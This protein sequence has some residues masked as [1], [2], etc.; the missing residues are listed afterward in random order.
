MDLFSNS[1]EKNQNLLPEDGTVVYY[2]HIMS[3]TNRIH[4]MEDFGADW[5]NDEAIIF[6]KLLIVPQKKK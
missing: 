2:G 4:Y 5:K 3:Q 6:G 1:E